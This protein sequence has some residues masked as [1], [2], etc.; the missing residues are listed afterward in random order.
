MSNS[1]LVSYTEISP[2][3]NSPRKHKID[4]ITI[5]CYVG[6]VTVE[7]MGRGFKS[8]ASQKSCN[9][10]IGRDGRIGMYVEEK[11]R[12][13]CTS[14][15]ENDHRA[16]TIECASDSTHPYAIN[17]AVYKSLIELCADICRR[18]GIKELKWRADKKLIGNAVAQ[19]MTV[20]RWFANKSCPGAYI[21]SRLGQIAKEVNAKLGVPE[22]VEPGVAVDKPSVEVAYSL[23]AFVKDVQ[24]AC[25]ASVD[26]K[27][28]PETLSKTVTISASKNRRHPVVKCIQKRLHALGYTEVGS[29]DGVAGA[30]FSKAVERYQAD[31]QCLSDGEITAKKTTWKTLLGMR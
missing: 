26:G 31:N 23:T 14:N 30:K 27:A 25:G 12:S 4:T 3:R 20:H 24:K 29:A 17:D 16:I 5:H 22:V 1:P 11:D 15:R 18:N 6:Q 28:G 21:Y 10:G 9:Y 19:N 2:N 7:R 8:K 13:W